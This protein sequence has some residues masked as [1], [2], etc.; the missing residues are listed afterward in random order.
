[1]TSG[2]VRRTPYVDAGG[3]P[4]PLKP[5]EKPV[6][7]VRPADRRTRAAA[8]GLTVALVFLIGQVLVTA[9]SNADALTDAREQLATSQQRA[10]DERARQLAQL[11]RL[12]DLV[13]ELTTKLDDRG[14]LDP[15]TADRLEAALEDA[16]RDL[17]NYREATGDEPEPDPEPGGEPRPG[18]SPRPTRSPRPSPTPSP[19]SCA[20]PA[21]PCALPT[22]LPAPL[23]LPCCP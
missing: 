1:M 7:V 9:K 4:L 12:L 17:A 18:A 23:P 14:Q 10:V 11:E 8:V 20:V 3:L 13:A 5:G 15:A 2:G 21:P 16:R 6:P 22:P 19:S